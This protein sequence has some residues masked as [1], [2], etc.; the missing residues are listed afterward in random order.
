LIETRA[1]LARA[2]AEPQTSQANVPRAAITDELDRVQHEN[3]V[4][5]QA[6]AEL[7]SQ[8]AAAQSARPQTGRPSGARIQDEIAKI[9][10]S[11]RPDP[12]FLRDRMTVLWGEFSDAAG[13]AALQANSP[14]DR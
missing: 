13:F 1:A 6:I 3:A 5:F 2:T 12:C 9:L 10:A 11:L 14:P 4:L 7:Q 8:L